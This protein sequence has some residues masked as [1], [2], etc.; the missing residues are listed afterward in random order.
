MYGISRT[1]A[2]LVRLDGFV[3]WRAKTADGASAQQV[4]SAL[5]SLLSLDARDKRV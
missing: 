1:G 5:C 2:V 3:G 4:A